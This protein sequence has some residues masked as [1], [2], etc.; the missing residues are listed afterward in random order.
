MN[1]TKFLRLAEWPGDERLPALISAIKSV[2]VLS[3]GLRFRALPAGRSC[4]IISPEGP[5][6]LRAYNNEK[7]LARIIERFGKFTKAGG[8][9]N[10]PF[11]RNPLKP[12]RA[13]EFITSAKIDRNL[14]F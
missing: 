8:V 12:L 11:S 10:G 2:R 9:E 5:G 13:R 7:R 3:Y 14:Y 4:P 6:V 1:A